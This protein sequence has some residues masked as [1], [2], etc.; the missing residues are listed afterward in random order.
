[1]NKIFTLL[2][3]GALTAGAVT[4]NAESQILKRKKESKS[5]NR[6]VGGKRFH[7]E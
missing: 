7:K 3:V 5:G 2:L 1:M 4:A 6:A